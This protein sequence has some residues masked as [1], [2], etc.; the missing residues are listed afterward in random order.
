[1]DLDIKHLVIGLV[2]EL[3]HATP[4]ISA[5]SEPLYVGTINDLRNDRELAP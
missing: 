4:E 5:E 2:Q 3:V 1:M